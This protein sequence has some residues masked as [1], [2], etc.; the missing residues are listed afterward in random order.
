MATIDKCIH[1]ESSRILF[2]S[3]RVCVTARVIWKVCP[4]RFKMQRIA[5]TKKHRNCGRQQ[6]ENGGGGKPHLPICPAHSIPTHQPTIPQKIYVCDDCVCSGDLSVS[7][8]CIICN[9][10]RQ[11]DIQCQRFNSIRRWVAYQSSHS[12]SRSGGAILLLFCCY[13]ISNVCLT[14]M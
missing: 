12:S 13:H 1:K 3:S 2:Y 7:P 9:G 14:A 6:T 8:G 5:A 4:V 11:C 10:Y